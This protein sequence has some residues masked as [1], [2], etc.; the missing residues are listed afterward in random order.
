MPRKVVILLLLLVT[1]IWAAKRALLVGVNDYTYLPAEGDL[2]GCVN[3]VTMAKELLVS[4]FGFL[5]EN[6][7]VLVDGEATE[8][9]VL[10][11]IQ[12]WLVTPGSPDDVAYFHFSGHGSQAQDFNGDEDD[13]RDEVICPSDF[14]P[15][16][17]SSIITDDQLKV[18]LGKVPARTITVVLDA[19]HSGTGTRDLSLSRPRF[20][21]F[22]T[23]RSQTRGLS[24]AKPV[25]K[26]NKGAG[27][28]GAGRGDQRQVTISGCRP[29]QTSADAWI[30]D[31][32]YAGALTYYLVENMK[33]A[34]SD[35]SYGELMERVVR[36]VLARNFSQV[37]QV[38]GEIDQPLLGGR[39]VEAV[40][41]N[42]VVAVV[43]FV[44]V[45]AAN[46]GK[47]RLKAG[48]AQQVTRG[49]VYAVYPPGETAFKGPGVAKIRVVSV[50]DSWANCVTPE[51]GA[52]NQGCRARLILSGL[53]VDKLRLLLET[54]DA[55]LQSAVQKAMTAYDFVEA[56][57]EGQRFDYRLQIRQTEGQVE[58]ALV[59]D[60]TPGG[61]V[62]GN[63]APAALAALRPQLENAYA[64]KCLS[65]LDNPDPPFK[66]EVWA[67]RGQTTDSLG[68][69][70]DEK[71][72]QA[73]IGTL[74]RFNFRAEKTCYL[75]LIDLDANGEVNVLFPNQYQPD[76]RIQAGKVYRTGIKGEMPFQIRATG[77][78]GREMVKVIASLDSL[79][80][81]SLKMGQ[82]GPAGTRRIAS[83]SEF[84]RQLIY[85][86]T[87]SGTAVG[88]SLP[89]T[90]TDKWV[91]D[92]LII[93]N[94]PNVP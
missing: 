37:P 24:L 7:K 73:Q 49:S 76:G 17:W 59:R 10:Q 39:D 78:A 45:D 67:N 48:Y 42:P 87:V 80:I 36:D 52:V 44:L 74:I 93:E 72:V 84:V 4:K 92:Y 66:V 38:E 54:P 22:D 71:S 33:K 50:G 27:S 15:G 43:P 19:C 53:E 64:T 88:D 90:R 13:G 1:P 32:F 6:V 69:A 62:S 81:P 77:P 35:M 60:G 94:V 65:V 55:V 85:D 63:D 30:R 57:A 51:G 14:Q 16:N 23:S 2:R 61:S 75:T 11:A 47:V 31:G 3:D 12:D 5:P 20:A 70:P 79:D 29:E 68:S 8:N 28:G 18:A 26:G 86:L 9:N 34:P 83:G 41:A 91:T 58:L 82:A 89:V 46:A 40:P 56:T 25:K 21:V